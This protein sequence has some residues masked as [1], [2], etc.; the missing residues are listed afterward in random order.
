MFA[1]VE[2]SQGIEDAFGNVMEFIPKLFGFLVVL[3]I[4]YIIAKAISKIADKALER[5][6]FDK[7]VEKG[8]IKTAL[9]KSQYDAS[10]IVGKVI[11]YG[12]FL[13]VLQAA[14]GVFG[15]NP[16]S[17][18]IASVI[19]FI[20]KV[21]VAI[22]IVVVM[23][24]IAAAAKV[25]VQGFLGTLSYA[26]ALANVAAGAIVAVGVFAALSQ[27]EIAP[28]I[29]NGL[30]YGLL[31]LVVGSGIIAI[32][33]GGV[34]PMQQV[35]QNSLTKISEEA[36]KMRQAAQ[37]GKENMSQLVEEGSDGT[38]SSD[39]SGVAARGR[40]SAS[41]SRTTVQERVARSPR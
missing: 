9:D 41:K 27:L 14:F 15:T 21:L 2:F 3:V 6:G 40:V 28:A 10:D 36:P 22:A 17:D 26:K 7:A 33:F 30:F 32:G 8:G 35:W 39:G 24:A 29:V 5:V 34:Q 38:D 31:A 37:A 19:A 1:A 13:L 20:P 23:S 16:I 18:L 11:F 4:G 12:L 25:M